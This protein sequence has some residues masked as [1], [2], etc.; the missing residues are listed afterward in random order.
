MCVVWLVGFFS[1][2]AH[3][4]ELPGIPRGLT[5]CQESW[6][7]QWHWIVNVLWYLKIKDIDSFGDTFFFF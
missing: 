7:D 6:A 4:T 1:V 5:D 2:G 3:L